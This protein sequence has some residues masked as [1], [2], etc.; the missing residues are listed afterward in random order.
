MSAMISLD[1]IPVRALNQVSQ[2]GFPNGWGSLAGY[3]APGLIP[4]HRPASGP[5]SIQGSPP[6]LSR[7]ASCP[8]PVWSSPMEPGRGLRRDTPVATVKL[9]PTE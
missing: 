5:P 7:G 2:R 3:F 6:F 1:L 8:I 9:T 4:T